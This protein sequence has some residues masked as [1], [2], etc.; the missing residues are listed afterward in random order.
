[1]AVL[2]KIGNNPEIHHIPCIKRSRPD[3][4]KEEAS[5]PLH[6]LSEQAS[7]IY[8]SFQLNEGEQTVDFLMKKFDEYCVPCTNVMYERYKS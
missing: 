1:M 3:D 4:D 2:L 6:V 5:I 8:N 7:E